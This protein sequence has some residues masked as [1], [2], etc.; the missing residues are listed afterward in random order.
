MEDG[1]GEERAILLA[2]DRVLAAQVR[3]PGQLEAGQIE[4]AQLIAKPRTSPRGRARF[5]SG[6]EALVDRLPPSASEGCTIRLEVTRARIGEGRRVKLAQARPSQESPC[7]APTLA[8][9]LGARVVRR[10]PA[11]VWEDL[12]EEAQDG[13]IAFPGGALT[14]TATPAMTLVDVDGVLPPRALA[15]AAIDPLARAIATLGLGGVIGV[16]FPTLQGKDD[17]KAVDVALTAGLADFDHERTAMNGFGFVQLVAR[18]ERP[19]LLHRWQF[20]P[21]GAAARLL[22]RAAE[23][24]RGTGPLLLT[25]A[26]PVLGAIRPAWL[27]ELSRRLG[28][29]VRTAADPALALAGGFAQSVAP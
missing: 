6:E 13:V 25:A 23:G 19:S 2:G 7:P 9:R 11:G 28:R 27:E 17:R 20:D 3:W 15:L 22:V 12:T 5:A 8:D 29:P 21:A 24:D 1:I 4:D 16:D 26:S 18:L 10:F 14:I